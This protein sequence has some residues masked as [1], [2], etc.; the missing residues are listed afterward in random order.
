MAKRRMRR[1]TKTPERQST[2][3]AITDQAREMSVSAVKVAT[4][5][6]RA[7]LAEMQDLGRTMADMAAPAARRAVKTANQATRATVDSARRAVRS[8]RPPSG[9]RKQG[10]RR[11]A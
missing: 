5:A 3:N 10:T 7:A 2:S 8:T 6:A 11:A 1:T 9:K 4:E